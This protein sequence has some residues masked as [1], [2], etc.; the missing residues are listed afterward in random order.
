MTTQT[1]ETTTMHVR[2]IP[3]DKIDPPTWDSRLPKTGEA[4]KKE[5]EEVA[6]L[7]QL[8]KAEGQLQPI[9]VIEKENGRFERIFGGRRCLAANTLNWTDIKAIVVPELPPE[10]RIMQNIAENGG[11]RDLSTFEVARAC[12]Q[13]RN[14]KV[15][16]KD[17]AEKMGISPQNV[18]HLCKMMTGLP[19]P[20][21]ADWEQDIDAVHVKFLYGLAGMKD[22]DAK[23]AKWEE[24][25][26]LVAAIPTDPEAKTKVKRQNASARGN[27][28]TAGYT[29]N[30]AAMHHALM[31]LTGKEAPKNLGDKPPT[32]WAV[33]LLHYVIGQRAKPPA[34]IPAPEVITPKT[35]GKK[36]KK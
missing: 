23:V 21:L 5:M 11:R 30:Q 34:G 28:H 26:A 29:L 10:D 18:S 13:L 33:E 7:A 31:F 20:I 9:K 1:T 2:S 4:A 14:M 15:A 24:R 19:A 3:L 36:S 25:K 22:D 12:M 6:K 35:K 17:V 16:G 8:L 32:K 27:G